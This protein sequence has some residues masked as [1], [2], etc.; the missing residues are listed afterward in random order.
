MD[1]FS[2]VL[3]IVD[4]GTQSENMLLS[5]P[6]DRAAIVLAHY[7]F[8]FLLIAYNLLLA[9]F[10]VF[11]HRWLFQLEDP[12]LPI[13]L[14]FKGVLLFY[15]GLLIMLSFIFPFMYKL[16]SGKGFVVALS[17]QLGLPLLKPLYRFATNA[18]QGI[19]ELDIRELIQL[20]QGAFRWINTQ[21]SFTISI[22]G[23]S[24]VLCIII[25]SLF[26]STRFYN[27]RDI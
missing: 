15:A 5:L 1:F 18:L 12:V 23:S 21:S 2:F 25:L 10:T 8:T 11:M 19:Y 20:L 7:A 26:L 6:L 27:K 9:L 13:I 14:N 3:M 16:G 17:L 24:T 4:A 22:L